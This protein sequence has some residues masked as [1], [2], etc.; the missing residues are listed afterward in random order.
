VRRRPLVPIC[1]AL[2]AGIV[3]ARWL[4]PPWWAPVSA[5]AAAA[6]VF[7]A[8]LRAERGSAL[9]YF[10]L[11]VLIA[12]AGALLY[13]GQQDPAVRLPVAPADGKGLPLRLRGTVIASPEFVERVSTL[14]PTADLPPRR[15]TRFELQVDAFAAPSGPWHEGRGRLRVSVHQWATA[16]RY[17]DRVEMAAMLSPL[18]HGRNPGEFDYAAY[19]RDRGVCG[20]ARVVGPAAVQRLGSGAIP[21]PFRWLHGARAALRRYLASRLP[22]AGSGVAGALV[23]G[24]RHEVPRRW[25]DLF[26]RTGTM[27]FLAVS[28]LHVA[29]VAGA[30]W[31]FGRKLRLGQRRTAWLA[32]AVVVA[33]ALVVGLRP[34]ILR[35][36][37]MALALL[38][39]LLRR[40]Q[41]DYLNIVALA[42]IIILA[43]NPRDLFDVGFQL[44]FAA[45]GFLSLFIPEWRTWCRRRRDQVRELQLRAESSSVKRLTL[46]ARRYAGSA[47]MVSLVAWL[48]AFPLMWRTFHLVTPIAVLANLIVAP[49]IWSLL[50]GGFV[51]LAVGWVP[52]LGWA[53]GY[54]VWGLTMLLGGCVAALDR[55]P[56]AHFYAAAPG[57]GWLVAYYALA[58]LFAGRRVL[59]LPARYVGY[60]AVALASA[61]LLVGSIGGGDGRLRFTVLDV[62]HGLSVFCEFP[63]G[64]H[65]LYDAGGFDSSAGERVIAPFLWHERVRQLD[66][67][68]LSHPDA[69]HTNGVPALLERFG[70][71]LVCV[72]EGFEQSELGGVLARQLRRRGHEL[73]H[74]VAGNRLVGPADIEIEVLNPSH[75][76][77]SPNMQRQND[78]SV[79]LSI[80]HRGQSLLLCGDVEEIGAAQVAVR[81][82]ATGKQTTAIVLPHHG[83]QFQGLAG[84]AQV[85]HAQVGI[86]SCGLN[87]VAASTIA[88]FESAGTQ[89]FATKLCGAVRGTFLDGGLRIERWDGA[90]DDWRPTALAE[91]KEAS[92]Q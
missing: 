16:V 91:P 60:A 3:F 65:L 28:G 1:A 78:R 70:I 63:D 89:V 15:S 82:R 74:L 69:D 66:A 77:V 37:L 32:A 58:L 14:R 59:R 83:A 17:G 79:V 51:L 13:L 19:L 26:A 62:G 80:T 54:G 85:V 9:C 68:V 8:A 31:F 27:H 71:G 72:D 75:G 90:A 81:L 23:L 21:W 41:R 67:L 86:A 10:S 61:F 38:V 49:L 24:A 48:G 36:S 25:R 29:L 84:F 87:G 43:I 4:A 33:Y 11:Y 76:M 50:V 45:V 18:G 53:V 7:F 52:V 88:A 22:G 6:A 44:S 57:A 5:T 55:V 40:R 35:A 56:W 92:V 34:S 39:A 30:A 2:A 46:L 12:A 47:A 64:S 20:V 42:A 73:V